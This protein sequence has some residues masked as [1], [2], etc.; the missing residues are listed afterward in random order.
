MFTHPNIHP[1]PHKRIVIYPLDVVRTKLQ[2][3]ALAPG[4]NKYS[5][6]MDCFRQ[7]M[8]QGGLRAFFNGLGFT[9]LRS[10]PVASAV[11]PM[12]DYTFYTLAVLLGIESP[13]LE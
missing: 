10:A 13:A 2:A 8:A 5:G 3:D 6:M 7:T 9:L 1:Q 11:L 12:Y 4:N